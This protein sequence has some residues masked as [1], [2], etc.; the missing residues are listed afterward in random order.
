V[1]DQWPLQVPG[2]NREA[3]TYTLKVRGVTT[4]GES[5]EIGSTSFELQIQN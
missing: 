1:Q 4:A 2:Q 5:K 3:G